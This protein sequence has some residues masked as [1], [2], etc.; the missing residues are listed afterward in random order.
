MA[1]PLFALIVCLLL[2]CPLAVPAQEGG[3]E[4]GDVPEAKKEPVPMPEAADGAG[5]VEVK[6][7]A[8][9]VEKEKPPGKP[10]AGPE[11]AEEADK[12]E[13][14]DAKPETPAKPD[15]KSDPKSDPK[16]EAR[17]KAREA[18]EAD[19]QMVETK[20]LEELPALLGHARFRVRELAQARLISGLE[21]DPEK[22]ATLSFD[23]FSKVSDPEIRMRARQI[24]LEHVSR[25]NGGGVRGFVGIGLLLHAFFDKGGEVQFA[26]KVS[27]IIPDTPAQKADLRVGDIITGIDDIKLDD[28]GADQRFM[29]L[30]AG[31]GAGKKVTLRYLRGEEAKEVEIIL[32]PR[33]EFLNEV[34]PPIDREKMLRDWLA[35]RKN[36]PVP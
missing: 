1:K 29:D 5:G 9:E 35:E 2:G 7:V 31:K 32:A 24:L 25:S 3:P 26:V 20:S 4:A 15:Q 11:E 16:A 17:A 10:E 27:Q 33:P 14:P 12:P 28:K 36:P 30:V 23:A 22:V 6:P 8:P 19:R 21:T 13:K 34:G 18:A